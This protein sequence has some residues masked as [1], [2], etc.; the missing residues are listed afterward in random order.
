[1]DTH[2]SYLLVALHI[3]QLMALGVK[4][5]GA[6]ASWLSQVLPKAVSK[7][8]TSNWLASQLSLIWTTYLDNH[9]KTYR[10]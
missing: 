1:L 8:S 4:K 10:L 2:F 3:N 9:F 6:G 5:L 7:T